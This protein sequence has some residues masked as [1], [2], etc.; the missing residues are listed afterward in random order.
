MSHVELTREELRQVLS[1]MR[2]AEG[3]FPEAWY[4]ALEKLERAYT[5]GPQLF[6]PVFTARPSGSE[7]L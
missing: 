7:K 5:D 3:R 2:A 6:P 4:T 1:T